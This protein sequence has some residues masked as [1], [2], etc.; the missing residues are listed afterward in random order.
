[1]EV[2]ILQDLL[3]WD[4]DDKYNNVRMQEKFEFRNHLC[5]VFECLNINLYEYIKSN[6]FKGSSM[7][8]VKRFAVQLLNSL[9][10][11][12][13][14]KLIHCDLKPENILLKHPTKS[15]IKVIDFGSSCLENQKGICF[16]KKKKYTCGMMITIYLF[17]LCIFFF[18]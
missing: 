18:L 14:H 5:I 13:Q 15:A 12:R 10:L 6:G 3:E 2:K 9:A 16:S 4:P 1:V 17:S 11:L 7:G 8:L